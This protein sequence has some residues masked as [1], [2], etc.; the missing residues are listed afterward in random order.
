MLAWDS[1]LALDYR[2]F[3]SFC[4][5]R[6]RLQLTR[7]CA[8]WECMAR[9]ASC[10][11]ARMK[12]DA[13]NGQMNFE[14]KDKLSDAFLRSNW[15]TANGQTEATPQDTVET[16]SGCFRRASGRTFRK[17]IRVKYSNFLGA[18]G[19][20]VFSIKQLTTGVICIL[21]LLIWHLVTGGVALSFK[22][23]QNE[24]FTP[25]G[26]RTALNLLWVWG[27]E[28]PGIYKH[29]LFTSFQTSVRSEKDQNVHRRCLLFPPFQFHWKQNPVMLH[30]RKRSKAT[31]STWILYCS[32][33]GEKN[34]HDH[35]QHWQQESWWLGWALLCWEYM[36]PKYSLI[37][38]DSQ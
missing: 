37:D 30:G 20:I 3:P 14:R 9:R 17:E 29:W 27:V 21:F 26:C 4:R 35:R 34:F 5:R 22:R 25:Y 12:T 10:E 6:G 13:L 32:K 31:S 16:G 19:L 38:I 24:S 2:S 23:D 11:W 18:G 8:A 36:P 7:V 1:Y 28:T 15:G 33:S